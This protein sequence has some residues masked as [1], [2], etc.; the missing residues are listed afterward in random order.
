MSSLAFLLLLVLMKTD[1]AISPSFEEFK[2]M[3]RKYNVIPV[4]TEILADLTT[5][6]ALFNRCIGEKD[7][8]LLES[9][10]RGEH[11]GRWSF[12]GGKPLATITSVNDE[13]NLEG[14]LPVAGDSE[15]G[16]LQLLTDLLDVFETPPLEDFPPLH[17]GVVGYLG[18]DLSLIHI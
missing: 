1:L 13:I 8:F 9:V 17:G 10:D 14:S 4:W 15:M 11:W 18:Y 16:L 5:P 3:A 12:I 6:V 2:D 7:G